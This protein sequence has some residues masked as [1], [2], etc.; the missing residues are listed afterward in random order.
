[1]NRSGS[2]HSSEQTKAVGLFI[3]DHAKNEAEF[4]SSQGSLSNT[5]SKIYTPC[6]YMH[7]HNKTI[8][9]HPKLMQEKPIRA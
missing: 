2:N 6:E 5:M 3:A 7:K 4:D 8:T 9:D 1:M